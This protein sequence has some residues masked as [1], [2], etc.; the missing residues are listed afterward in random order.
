MVKGSSFR[1]LFF[2]ISYKCVCFQPVIEA[3][4]G[5]TINQNHSLDE[6]MSP[7]GGITQINFNSDLM[8]SNPDQTRFNQMLFHY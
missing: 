7:P 4:Q 2:I 5:L 1:I 6:R 8:G 3:I